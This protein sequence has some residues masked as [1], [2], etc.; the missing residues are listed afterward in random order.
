MCN[1]NTRQKE[2]REWPS[3]VLDLSQIIIPSNHKSPWNTTFN[4][5]LSLDTSHYE[6]EWLTNIREEWTEVIMASIS[7][8]LNIDISI[9]RNCC[10]AL[11]G[12]IYT[13]T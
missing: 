4:L 9:Q 6:N 11:L 3:E 2:E 7:N 10:L 5:T 12:N 1:H 8:R 13:E